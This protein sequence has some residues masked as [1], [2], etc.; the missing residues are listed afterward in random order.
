MAY[1]EVAMWEILDV[2]ERL[3]RRESKSAVARATG[4]SR[5][6]V[7]RYAAIARDL[8]WTPGDLVDPSGGL[9]ALAVEVSKRMRPVGEHAL[10]EAQQ[11]LMV[12]KDQIRLWLKPAEGEKRGLRLTKVHLLLA[13]QGA[14][15]P[16]STLHRFAIKHCGF[17]AAGRVTVRM[18]DVSP[19]ELAEIDF[20]RLGL[21]YDPETHRKRA[22]WALVV[23]LVH[24]RHQYVHV[25]FTQT[26]RSVIEGLEDAWSF[27]GGVA[28]RVVLDNLSAAISKADRYDPIFQRTMAEYARYRGIVI[29]PA[30]VRM[31]TGKPHVERG[32]PYVRENF[33]RGENW[34]DIT[35]VKE[36]AI[37]WCRETAGQRIHG[38]TR[39]RPLVVFENIERPALKPLAEGRFDPPLWARCKVHPDHHISFG[40]ALY[41]VPTRFIGNSL[42]VRGDSTLVRIYADHELIKTHALKPPGGRSTDHN[43]YPEALT[44]YTLRDPS[45]IIKEAESRG[46]NIGRFAAELLAGTF[47]WA[48]LRQAQG[49]LRLG[50]KYGW[51]R[52]DDACQRA[53]AFELVNVRRVESILRLDLGQIDASPAPAETRVYEFQPRFA[54]AATSFAHHA[55]ENTGPSTT[56]DNG[57]AND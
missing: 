30:P 26:T 19:G 23:V 15:V 36:S 31:P 35:H 7:R 50:K 46:T 45:R 17:G 29:D 14:L 37:K 48:K 6:T 32:V 16:Y 1:H 4:Y 33:F 39:Q 24:S 13:R 53:L 5:S 18:A 57:A 22:A 34:R 3:K 43:D 51:H 47:P 49:L 42:W 8:G 2:L 38:S 52:L 9:E 44:S 12:H 40:K 55:P 25:T 21:V 41:S 10:S 27:F 54:R 28:L 11:L 20:G 56:H